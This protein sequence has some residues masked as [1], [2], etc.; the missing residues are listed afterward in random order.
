MKFR[1][2]DKWKDG[3]RIWEKTCSLEYITCMDS[4]FSKTF[5]GF[6]PFVLLVIFLFTSHRFLRP[7]IVSLSNQ[8]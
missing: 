5:L 3:K 8:W 4:I 1:V 7:C 2:C 6:L